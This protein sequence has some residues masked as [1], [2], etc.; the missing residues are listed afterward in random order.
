M[1][2]AALTGSD[3]R[4][5]GAALPLSLLDGPTGAVLKQQAVDRKTNE[6][7]A[8]FDLL[9]GL[10]L[11]GRVVT[12]DAMFCH[13]DFAREIRG[14]AGHCFFEVK[15]NQEQLK[16]DIESA[17]QPAFS[18]RRAEAAAAGGR[19]GPDHRPLRGA[20]GVAGDPDDDAA[21]RLPASP[22]RCGRTFTTPGI[23]SPNRPL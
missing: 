10:I 16:K 8:A 4:L 18:P 5:R 11:R 19:R 21:E 7:K 20:G 15:G 12:A 6:H 3:G 9:Q 17:F 2:G 13:R 22:R 23:P 14:R 1:D